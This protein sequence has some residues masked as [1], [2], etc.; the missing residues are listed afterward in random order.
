MLLHKLWLAGVILGAS[1]SALGLKLPHSLLALQ[2]VFSLQQALCPHYS[3]LS[4]H[5]LPIDLGQYSGEIVARLDYSNDH[6]LKKALMGRSIFKFKKWGKNNVLQT[7]DVQLHPDTL[8]DMAHQFPNMKYEVIIDDLAQKVY[9]TYPQ[10]WASSKLNPTRMNVFSELFFKEYRPL[11][12]I[13]AWLNILQET[14]PNQIKLETIGYTHENRPLQVVHFSTEADPDH[15]DKR[16]V[17]ITGGIHA[18]EWI[19]VS[20]VLYSI[21]ELLQYYSANPDSSI[22]SRL[23]FLFIPVFNPDGYEYTW[24]SDRLWRKNRQETVNPNCLGIDIDHSFDFHW[25]RSSDWECG[26]EYS[27]EKPFEAL[28]SKV[29]DEYLNA[30]N[31][32]HNIYGFIDLH[33]Y[34]QEVLYPYAYSCANQ[35][36]DEENLI[37]LAYGISKTIRQESGKNYNVMPACVDKDADL[38]PDLGAGSSLD[39]MYHN[40]AYR[41]YQLKL[42]DS[43]SHG[44]LLPGKYIEPVGKEIFAGIKY[45]CIFILGDD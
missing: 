34:S 44:F 27:G 26:E 17:V 22:L 24:S 23:D 8:Q 36:R 39:F 18:R 6:Q 40:K 2:N 45:F 5:E 9:E 11:E 43:G 12:T 14:F 42:R 15:S 19:S 4:S 16:T 41:A 31:E 1:Q 33:S 10:H 29:W 21:Y 3:S 20:S 13:N 37:E 30:T 28:E 7:M 38:I 32:N 25:T 35:P